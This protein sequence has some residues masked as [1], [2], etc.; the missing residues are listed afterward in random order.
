MKEK[1]LTTAI[2]LALTLTGIASAA[3][4]ED[5]KI[6]YNQGVTSYHNG[7]YE[8]AVSLFKQ[9]IATDANYTDAYYNLGIV[10]QQMNNLPEALNTFKQII[11]RNP[12]DYEA[13]LNAATLS[14]KLGQEENAKKYLSIIPSTSTVYANAQNLAYALNTDI[15]TIKKELEQKAA[16]A[17]AAAQKAAQ[18]AAQQAAA[19]KAAAD[20]ATGIPQS[21]GNYTNLASP[22][23]ITTDNSGNVYVAS[24]SSNSITKITPSGS[25]SVFVKSNKLNGPIDIESDANG[26]IYVANYNIDNVVKITPSGE[27]SQLI[28]GIK[29]PYCLHLAGGVLFIS[30]QGSNTVV[31]YKL[32]N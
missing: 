7:N 10:L 25:R 22:T 4:T 13:I 2:V 32:A 9:A 26:N 31:R 14:A 28:G 8:Q 29:K 12:N 6:Y 30:S 19:A 21:N 3:G 15:P 23:G 17:Q 18:E 5:A 16:E 20:K 27:I 11:V 1:I 24:F